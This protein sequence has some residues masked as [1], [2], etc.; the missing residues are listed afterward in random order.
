MVFF[1]DPCTQVSMEINSFVNF[2]T[3]LQD[4]KMRPCW[5][6]NQ[7]ECSNMWHVNAHKRHWHI[8]LPLL[9]NN[10]GW[11]NDN[12]RCT[13]FS[14]LCLVTHAYLFTF[15]FMRAGRDIYNSS[16]C[17]CLYL[18]VCLCLYI[19]MFINYCLCLLKH[20]LNF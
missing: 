3:V 20:L 5:Q 8:A 1:L 11:P 17:A 19:R 9:L 13:F 16:L 18:C 12:S 14:S 6:P 4:L 10:L 7:G 2:W 15:H